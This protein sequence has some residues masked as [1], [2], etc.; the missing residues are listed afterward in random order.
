VSRAG[1]KL[2]H[3]LDAFGVEPA[4]RACLDLG[5]S[6]GGF[7]DVLLQRRARRIVAVDVGHGQLHARLA[8]DPR[9]VALERTDAR[10]LT[11]ER[12]GE[13]PTL[14]TADL[15]FIGLAKALPV[16]LS[17]AA[18]RADLVALI[19]PQFEAGPNAGKAGVLPEGVARK[20]AAETIAAI[21]GME[22]FAVRDSCDSPIRG[23]EGN[24]EIFVHARR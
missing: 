19:K 21:D 4:G 23:A 5:A 7:A 2:A 12:I 13:A 17:L 9:V 20:A 24:L 22:G 11:R 10:A 3:A 16:P 14:I 15:S 18:E 1:L 6:T 8:R